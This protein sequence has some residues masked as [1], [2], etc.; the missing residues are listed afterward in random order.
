M[1]N[2]TGGEAPNTQEEQEMT[3]ILARRARDAARTKRL[4]HPRLRNIGADIV[5][6]HAQMAEKKRQKEVL[7]AAEARE[8]ASEQQ[9]RR[10]L[11]ALAQEETEAKYCANVQ[12]SQDW[13]DQEASRAGRREG[14]LATSVRQDLT[15]NP[16]TCSVGAA[17]K[18]EGE[19]VCKQARERLQA[20]QTRAW[21]T[22][23]LQ[24]KQA[25]VSRTKAQDRAYAAQVKAQVTFQQ[26]AEEAMEGLKNARSQLVAR[27]NATLLAA[28]ALAK[29]DAVDRNAALDRYAA[30]CADHSVLLT[31]DQSHMTSSASSTRVRTDHWKGMS[32]A[33]VVT[34]IRS[35]A[36][37]M[38]DKQAVA[39]AE[40]TV[41]ATRASTQTYYTHLMEAQE[42]EAA[43]L[44]RAQAIETSEQLKGQQVEHAAREA[45]QRDASR[46][47]IEPRFFQGFGTSFR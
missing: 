6:I 40:A 23:Q 41:E 27:D 17:Q 46:G 47:A 20:A 29:Q 8:L 28:H 10:Y 39:D 1:L 30:V 35:N 4:H 2:Q 45:S 3:R 25:Q 13:K 16:D 34:I 31:E 33:Q 9:I 44:K 42:V 21:N 22:S 32:K 14:D 15:L 43:L 11:T 38:A 19:D 37:L 36:D 7:H 26:E 5:G 12:L 24:E 18:F